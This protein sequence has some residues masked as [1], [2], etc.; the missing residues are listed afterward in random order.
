MRYPVTIDSSTQ[1][2][3]TNNM[4]TETIGKNSKNFSI[5][6]NVLFAHNREWLI[7]EVKPYEHKGKMRTQLNVTKKKG[8]KIFRM[9]VYENGII[10]E[11][12]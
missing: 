6:D 8:K 4:K 9:F 12:V 11:A 1:G 3:E 2:T 5:Q 10:S 7:Q